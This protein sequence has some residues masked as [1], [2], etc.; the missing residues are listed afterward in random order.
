MLEVGGSTCP[1]QEW[2]SRGVDTLADA[3]SR[4][5]VNAK[6]RVA[7]RFFAI[8]PGQR[9]DENGVCRERLSGKSIGHMAKSRIERKAASRHVYSSGAV[10]SWE[11]PQ[12]HILNRC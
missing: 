10:F 8:S 5:P 7:W 4:I 6:V 3:S 12:I 11:P 1:E 2:N 9:R